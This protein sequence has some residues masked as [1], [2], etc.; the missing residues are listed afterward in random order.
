[1]EQFCIMIFVMVQ[2]PTPVIKFH[3]AMHKKVHIKL[4]YQII[5]YILKIFYQYEFSVIY[6]V[7]NCYI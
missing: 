6:N 1:M 2:K 3:R 5:I 7:Y 4:M